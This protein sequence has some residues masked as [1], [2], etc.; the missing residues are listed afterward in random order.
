MKAGEFQMDDNTV[1]ILAGGV[2][3]LGVLVVL[4]MLDVAGGIVSGNNALTQNQTNADGERVDAY[5]G[6]GVAG[7]VG[8][9]ANTVSG[10]ILA[11]VGQAIGR[12][13]FDVF[14]PKVD[15]NAPAPKL[16]RPSTP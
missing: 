7:T 9:A 4:G 6:K 12:W 16:D 1:L 5:E 13:T 3:V 2:A 14:G 8:A 10:G 11:S 15:I